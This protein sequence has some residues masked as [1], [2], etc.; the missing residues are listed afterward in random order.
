MADTLPRT[1][2]AAFAMGAPFA[3]REARHL[4]GAREWAVEV[5]AGLDAGVRVSLRLD[6]SAYELFD[7]AGAGDGPAGDAADGGP[8]SAARHAGAAITQVHSLADP[9][10][11]VDAAAL[12]NGTAGEP[13]GPRARIDAVLA[14]RRA[15]RVWAPLE[16]LLDQPVPDVLALG[17]DELQEL[18][19]A[20]G[21]RLS[22]AG[23][24]VHGP[25]SSPAPSQRRPS[26]G[27]PPARPPTAPRSSTP[28]S[29]S[30]STGSSRWGTRS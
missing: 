20:G 25:G 26:C 14:L 27:P 6:L 30:A 9:T 12:W 24:S 7:T 3:A 22:A 10:Y 13:F 18:L 16:R 1:P 28:N 17:E 29:S 15:S 21:A 2:A 4:P 11:V 23:V 5:A 8:P 19:G